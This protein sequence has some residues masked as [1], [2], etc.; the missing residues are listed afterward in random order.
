M[1]KKALLTLTVLFF[2]VSLAGAENVG[3]V[4]LPDTLTVGDAS[5]LLNGGGVRKK[6]GLK[7]YSG[8]LY[9][10]AKN[11][12]ARAIIA[13][14][15]P[16]AIRLHITSG[17]ITS[18]KMIRAINDGFENATQGHVAALQDEIAA[19]T[20]F[21]SAEIKDGDVFD[22]KYVPGKGVEA[23]KNGRSLG[24]IKGL[25]FKKALMGIWLC[26]KPADKRLKKGMLGK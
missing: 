14:D 10:K 11:T 6:I 8:G 12:D 1:R 24:V 7:L 9:L 2:S 16:M 18:E 5:L 23:V 4:N 17:L 25:A 3:K 15:A 21:F 19:F 20:H 13:A 22:L 26:D